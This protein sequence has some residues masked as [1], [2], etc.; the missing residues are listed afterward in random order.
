MDFMPTSQRA[1]ERVTGS[2]RR[3]LDTFAPLMSDFLV[4][5]CR[6]IEVLTKTLFFSYTAK[7]PNS[8]TLQ[9]TLGI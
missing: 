7:T 2:D 4:E 1:D 3:L 6:K 5:F 8:C 9:P